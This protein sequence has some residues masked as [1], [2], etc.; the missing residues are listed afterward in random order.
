MEMF[1][2]PNALFVL[3]H[4]CGHQFIGRS[5][6][7]KCAESYVYAVI[8]DL[9][10]RSLG[11]SFKDVEKSVSRPLKGGRRLSISEDVAQISSTRIRNKLH[12]NCGAICDGYWRYYEKYQVEMNAVLDPLSLENMVLDDITEA[13]KQFL[14]TLILNDWESLFPIFQ[15]LFHINYTT[16]GLM[17]QRLRESNEEDG[18]FKSMELRDAIFLEQFYYVPN[19]EDSEVSDIPDDTKRRIERTSKQAQMESKRV[20]AAIC[21]E[22][23]E[24][25]GDIYS[26]IFAIEL[27]GLGCEKGTADRL[28]RA[29]KYVELIIRMAGALRNEIILETGKLIRVRVVLGQCYCIEET[30]EIISILKKIGIPG[31]IFK[32][33]ENSLDSIKS[34]LYYEEIA[35]FAK[36]CQ[37]ELIQKRN[38]LAG[39]GGSFDLESVSQMLQEMYSGQTDSVINNIYYFWKVSTQRKEAELV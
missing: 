4:E 32:K 11:Y 20:S 33:A 31:K 1:D 26:D 37:E 10:H 29:Q 2:V 12:E 13:L 9:L 14:D 36:I 38:D 5:M 19:P 28:D 7:K 18:C 39:S 6:R 15:R 25:Y 30:S 34:S 24:V 3:L 22:M 8:A 17:I 27:L 16:V 21:D 35:H 23:N